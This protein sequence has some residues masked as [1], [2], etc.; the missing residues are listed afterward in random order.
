MLA[1]QRGLDP[2][3]SHRTQSAKEMPQK[4]G[5]CAH[6]ALVLSFS[7]FADAPTQFRS[8][9]RGWSLVRGS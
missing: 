8:S 7:N 5:L 1:G 2:K 6:S 4:G 3:Q 9:E